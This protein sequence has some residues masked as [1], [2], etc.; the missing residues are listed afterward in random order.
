MQYEQHPSDLLSRCSSLT[1]CR[2][3][4]R[5]LSEMRAVVNL[6]SNILATVVVARWMGELDDERLNLVL[7][8]EGE[9]EALEPALA[10][11]AKG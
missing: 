1:T 5:F 9:D 11:G 3:P 7:V 6:F 10:S 8:G 2:P 4:N